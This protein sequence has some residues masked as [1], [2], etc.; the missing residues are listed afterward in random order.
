MRGLSH[1]RKNE[2]LATEVEDTLY[3]ALLT[4]PPQPGDISATLAEADFEG[5]ARAEVAP[6]DWAPPASGTVKTSATISFDP[7]LSGATTIVGWALLT[8]PSGGAIRWFG[9]MA[10]R[11]LDI[12]D[13]TFTVAAGALSL[14]LADLG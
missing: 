11:I 3:L 1:S 13:P 7:L 4:S 12:D 6:I 8:E 2:I 5:Y 9:G 14:S 10:P